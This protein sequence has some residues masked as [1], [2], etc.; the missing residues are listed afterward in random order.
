[1]S[2]NSWQRWHT[3]VT[4]LISL[5]LVGYA[6]WP[7]LL[8]RNDAST[9]TYSWLI[10]AALLIVF[11]IVIG[12][13]ITGRVLGILINEHN[14][15][16]LS[17]FQMVLWTIVILSG[18]LTAVTWN[19]WNNVGTAALAIA[20]PVQV[21]GLLGISVTSL[22]GTPIILDPKT[23]KTP[24]PKEQETARNRL[25]PQQM[26]SMRA[27]NLA[28][29]APTGAE[30]EA[31]A[32]DMTGVQFKGLV[33]ARTDPARA[34]FGDIFTGDE[35]GTGGLVDVGKVQ[36]FFFT[37]VIALAYALN[38]SSILV[39]ASK[40]G[41]TEFPQLDS[42]MVALLG[43]SNAGYLGYKAAPHTRT[44]EDVQG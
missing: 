44:T 38:I 32:V 9:N 4:I 18:W 35:A 43:I 27:R 29:P 19:L 10:F 41:I 20:I 39:T 8:D 15:M 3:V 31:Q 14:K 5:M 2:T 22:V 13:G 6:W 12:L 37:L 40:N 25:A 30:A 36:M 21:W 26:R 7:F 17:R 34:E 42:S 24:A 23:R 28:Q 11:V 16:S 33:V 1:M